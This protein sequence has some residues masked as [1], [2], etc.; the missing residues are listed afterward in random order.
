MEMSKEQ[1]SLKKHRKKVDRVLLA[2]VWFHGI[3]NFAAA[4]WYN[5]MQEAIFIGAPTVGIITFLVLVLPGSLLTRNVMGAAFMVFSA[6]LI[7]QGHG[8]I[9]MHFGIF[10][11]LAFL[12]YYRDWMP[13]ITAAAVIA[14][15][16][17]TFNY[18]QASGYPV[19]IFTQT[20]LFIVILH[21][22][23]VVF[24]SVIL[25]I[26]AVNSKKEM[27]ILADHVSRS[28][29]MVFEQSR[30]LERIGVAV[31]TL[32]Q[33]SDQLY[34]SSQSL[35]QSANEE[36][37][38]IEETSATLDQMMAS[39]QHNS[40]N[41]GITDKVASK[42]SVEAEDG[43]NA[44]KETVDAMKTI[45]AKVGI[46]DDIA[47]QTNLL[48]LNAAIEAARAGEH[49]KGF[50]VVAAEVRKLA[51]RSQ[52]AAKEISEVAGGSL[53]ISERA[54]KLLTEIVTSIKKTS[55]LVKEIANTSNEQ[56][57]N[58]KQISTTMSQI[59]GIAQQNA[60]TA[61]ELAASAEEIKNQ[62]DM[63]YKIMDAQK[64]D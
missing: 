6:L 41:A 51:E 48:A 60:A 30:I 39:I 64:H 32:T 59:E 3:I 17:L 24:E 25:V 12:L 10:V 43:G 26:M 52:I 22:G 35:S 54:G 36:A 21:A 2:V 27:L 63:L 19:F 40:E 55:D 4:P 61:E 58:A 62:T 38:G 53:K 9:E 50:A 28:D 45:A 23:Y 56:S 49:G 8:M 5:T 20:G 44:V 34:S 1:I 15:H 31:R 42:T 33:A 18:L 7:H 11:L 13:I 14:V 57:V 46:I 37:A 47:Y 29:A 16:H